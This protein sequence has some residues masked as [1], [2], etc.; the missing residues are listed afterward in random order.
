MCGICG[1]YQDPAGD[2]AQLEGAAERM[3]AC[4]VHRGPDDGGVWA[5]PGGRA[6]LGNRRLAIIDLSPAGHQ[7]MVAAD[8]DVVLTYNGEIYNFQELREGLVASGYPFRGRSDTE[9]ILALYLREGK[10]MC[11]RL[12][13]MFALAIWD[14][15]SR[16]LLLAR[17]RLGIK[18]L[19]YAMRGGRCVFAQEIRAIRASGLLSLP[20]NPAALAAFLRLGS[21]P[22][23][24]TAFAG[25]EEL[26]P[27]HVLTIRDGRATPERYWELPALR[28]GAGDPETAAEVIRERLRSAVASHLVSDVPLGV[29]LSGGMDSAAIVA[30]MRDAG[31]DRIRTFS[32]TFP[33]REFDEGGDA[34]RLAAYYQT[35]HTASEVRGDDLAADLDGIV[36]AMDQPTVDGINTYYVSRVTRRSGTIVALSGLGGDELFCGYPS[37]RLTPRVLAWQRATGR[38]AAARPVLA[39][40]L[41]AVPSRRS[42]KLRESLG[43]PPTIQSAYL[44]VRGLMSREETVGVLAPGPLSDAARDFD[45]VAAIGALA[46]DTPADPVAATGVL[47]LRGYM[48]NQLLRDTDVMSMAHSLEVRVPFLDHPLVEYAAALP[49]Q[50]RADGHAPKWLLRKALGTLVPETAGAVKRGF[51]F[52]LGRWLNGPLRP[53]AQ[54]ALRDVRLFRPAAVARLQH[55]VARGRAHWSRLW[56]LVVLSEWMRAVAG[57]SEALAG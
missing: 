12:R 28:A 18:P 53:R 54:D 19:Y 57:G 26:P 46:P 24:M 48:H 6:A 33:E 49:G 38:I 29:F 11:R 3:T 50:L 23:P 1:V 55:Q 47:E 14:G 27:A 37:F 32:I 35:E 15:R 16:E 34:A 10:A 56:V 2:P 39:A 43:L 17:D 52:P 4:L 30:L 22:A 31:H 5:D 45:A 42:A 21:V 44:T 8:G 20:P 36:A 40:A 51:T 13:G 41:A 7:P 25:V 9:V